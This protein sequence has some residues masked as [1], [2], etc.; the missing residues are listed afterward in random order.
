MRIAKLSTVTVPNALPAVQAAP[1]APD[2]VWLQFS[3]PNA[4]QVV[5]LTTDRG[6]AVLTGMVLTQASGPLVL[7]V[8]EVGDA[9]GWPWYAT[10]D[11][12]GTA[13]AVL[14]AMAPRSGRGR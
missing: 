6:A 13:L 10:S 9:V 8:E 4:G 7:R 1:A 5:Y 3:P 14:E 12:N 11:V 2:R